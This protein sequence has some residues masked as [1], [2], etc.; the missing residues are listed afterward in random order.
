MKKR[1]PDYNKICLSGGLF[2]NVKLNM[3]L[4]ELDLFD[5]IYI[6]PAMSDSGLA[7]GAALKIAND[8]GEVKKTTQI[9]KMC[10]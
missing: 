7:L 5:E 8:L 2:A 3:Y 6:H 10:F 1:F 4:N 9:K